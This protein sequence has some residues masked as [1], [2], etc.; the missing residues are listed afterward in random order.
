MALSGIMTR[1]LLA[2]DTSRQIAHVQQSVKNKM[3]AH[4]GVLGAEIKLDE[5]RGGDVTKKKE[6]LDEVNKK[7]ASLGEATIKTLTSANEELEKAAK[8]DKEA[9]KAAEKKKAKKVAKKKEAEKL[10]EKK[11]E[12]KAVEEKLE[13]TSEDVEGS[14]VDALKG[15]VFEGASVDV[16]VDTVTPSSIAPKGVG[17]A[18]DIKA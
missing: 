15:G 7:A 8:E 17:A 18:V 12:K 4:A 10:A 11:S 1:S 3:D 6:E 16:V 9:E 2:A 5:A 14:S 13:K